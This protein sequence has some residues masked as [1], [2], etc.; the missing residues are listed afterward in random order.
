MEAI[1]TSFMKKVKRLPR[2]L[3]AEALMGLVKAEEWNRAVGVEET[4]NFRMPLGGAVRYFFTFYEDDT[5]YRICT[6][7]RDFRRLQNA[8][9]SGYAGY[10]LERIHKYADDDHVV[11]DYEMNDHVEIVMQK[12][13]IPS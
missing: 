9:S 1:K 3:T 10:I 5:A 13:R 7:D 8:P 11:G 12:K 4:C 2:P 6:I